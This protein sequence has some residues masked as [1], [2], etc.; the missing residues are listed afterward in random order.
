MASQTQNHLRTDCKSV[1]AGSRTP[2]F[3]FLIF[4]FLFFLFQTTN[5]QH[6]P[7]RTYTLRDGL[8][9][10]QATCALADSRGYLWVGT[11]GGLAKFDG[12]RFETFTR[13]DFGQPTDHVAGLAEDRRHRLWFSTLLGLGCFDGN[14]FESFPFGPDLKNTVCP[15]EFDDRDRSWLVSRDRDLWCFERGRYRPARHFIRGLDSL[16]FS[17]LQWDPVRKR[18]WLTAFWGRND[19]EARLCYLNGDRCECLHAYPL[20]AGSLLRVEKKAG[21]L[22]LRET[23]AQGRVLLRWF[24]PEG[25]PRPFLRLDGARVQVLEPVP[26]DVWGMAGGRVYKVAAGS[27]VVETVLESPGN[28]ST[29]I[30]R[31]GDKVFFPTEKGLIEVLDNGLRFF[32]EK[33]AP[34]VW[35][36]IDRPNGDVWFLNYNHPPGRYRSPSDAPTTVE[37][38]VEPGLTALF[39]RARPNQKAV[40]NN[41]Y[42]HPAYDQRGTLYLPHDVGLIA[43][44]GQDWRL[45]AGGDTNG[46]VA[47]YVYA[48]ERT[49]DRVLAGMDGGFRVFEGGRQVRKLTQA[50]GMHPCYYGLCALS[51]SEPDTYWLGSWSGL[52]RYHHRTGRFEHFTKANGKLPQQSVADLCR[53]AW[54]TLWLATREGLARYDRPTDRVLSVAPEVLKNILSFVG[55]LNDSTLAVGD[56][57]GVYLLNLG[58]YHRRGRVVLQLLNHRTG[59]V[60]IEPGQAGFFKDR[61]GRAWM[62]TGTL[63]TMLDT[64]RFRFRPQ[65]LRPVVRTLN[66][67]RLPFAFADSVFALPGPQE[68]A[69]VGF[70]AL[71]D[72]R[73]ARTQWAW[74]LDDG[75]WSDWQE[76]PFALLRDYGGGIHR[77][78]LRARSGGLN[79][80]AERFATLHFRADIPAFEAP[81]F[82]R[83]LP[84][85]LLALLVLVGLVLWRVVYERRQTRKA[86]RQLE[87][88]AREALFLNVQTLQSQLNTHFLFNVLVPLQ[89]LILQNRGDEAAR[90]LVEFSNLV[91]EFLNSSALSNGTTQSLIEREITLADEISLLRRYVGF[92]QLLYRDKLTV[93]FGDESLGGNINP[94]TVTLPPM[95][96][97][98]YVE[99]AIK[100]GLVHKPG[101]GNLWI[102]FVEVDETLVCT[103]EDD[104]IGREG[105]KQIHHTSRRAYK[106]LGSDLVQRRVEALNQLGYAIR[107]RTDDRLA[108]GTVVTL[109]IARSHA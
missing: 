39:A 10:M 89:N 46:G 90:L 29:G 4:H 100:H 69:R 87:Q 85:L 96:I 40:W 61:Q 65:P 21:A 25:L 70:E 81:G 66:G 23:D 71:G 47:M 31:L 22:L 78:D 32:D 18:L 36:V 57:H 58:E 74:R 59:F 104:G 98:P 68:R 3:S 67:L 94:E 45:L 77:F 97:Q 76:E 49:P 75:P 24:P 92:E 73:P 60:G 2:P 107:I 82:R 55:L 33:Q 30:V 95:L 52:S 11:K 27:R 72:N 35:S 37:P 84:Y 88:R 103:I 56:P 41:F 101:P 99:N 80:A 34:Y 62:T 79:E 43:H 86:Q 50:E 105:M 14:R 44:R 54:G 38:L 63:L 20:P 51:A 102:R 53:D 16:K 7:T 91:R 5:A 64:R 8:P 15:I 6:Y 109:T 26:S 93:H 83:S 13:Q 28:L 1:R 42:F 17:N 108:G 106:S 9:Q 48:D 12:E 19:R